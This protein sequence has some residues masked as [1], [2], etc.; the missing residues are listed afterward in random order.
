M[1][2]CNS[3]ISHPE[4]FEIRHAANSKIHT[5]V[6][7][8]TV[9]AFTL[10]FRDFPRDNTS[11]FF[12]HRMCDKGWIGANFLHLAVA[13]IG[14]VCLVDFL[15]QHESSMRRLFAYQSANESFPFL[16]SS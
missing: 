15:I 11:V 9:S 10:W 6:R 5:S 12:H 8:F 16:I 1:P 2:S 4:K 3:K 14:R 13:K 7:Y